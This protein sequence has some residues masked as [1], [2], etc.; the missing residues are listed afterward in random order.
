[1]GIREQ[2]ERIYRD[3]PPESIPWNHPD[4]PELLAEA[5]QTGRIKPCRAVDLGCG[6]GNYAVW[7]ARQG[8]DVTGIDISSEAVKLAADLSARQGVSCRFVVA[9]L[10]GDLKEYHAAF[11]LAFDW[12]LLHHVFPKDRP[13]YIRNVHSLLVPH[14]TYV[15]ACFNDGDTAFGGVGKYRDT[16]LGTTLYFSSLEELK[17]LY[18]PLFDV[19]E[20][21][22]VQIPGRPNPH[23][24]NFAWLERK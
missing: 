3:I 10:L 15:S 13:R 17:A 12:E 16:P 9:D 5:V 14:G 19:V 18:T 23:V 8:F 1:V 11:D 24:A 4:P 22:T 6:T 7:L 20:L 21:R 2:M